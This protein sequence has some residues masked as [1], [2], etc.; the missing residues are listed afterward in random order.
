MAR[1]LMRGMLVGL[2]AGLL[3]FGFA[4]AFGEPGIERSIAVEDAIAKTKGEVPEPELVSRTVQSTL[5][6]LTGVVVAGTALGGLFSILFAIGH[7]RV[8]HLGARAFAAVLALICFVA[9]ALV[10]FLKYPANPPAIGAPD[11]IGIRTGLYMS[12]IAVSIIAM[13][14]AISLRRLL[15]PRLGGWNAA[16]CAALAFVG[17]TAIAFVA[18]PVVNEVPE[19]FPAQTL[20]NFRLVSLGLQAILWG[21]I[22]VGFGALAEDRR[23]PAA[24]SSG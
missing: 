13:L 11:T 3:A 1:L 2:V 23:T 17:M 21:T 20:W 24:Q 4:R 6:L 14:A 8:S 18:F 10:P 7:G 5:G 9:V 19:T 22:G 12:C 16:L 15:L